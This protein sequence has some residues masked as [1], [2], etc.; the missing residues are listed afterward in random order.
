[1]DIYEAIRT[2]ETFLE[3]YGEKY[4]GPGTWAPAETKIVPSG[5]ENDTIKIW[6]NLGDG[7]AETE[8]EPMRA[9]FVKD[10]TAAHPGLKSFTLSVRAEAF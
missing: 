5:D 1:M 8:V 6:F 2:I 7:I 4:A 3:T 9:A 10:V